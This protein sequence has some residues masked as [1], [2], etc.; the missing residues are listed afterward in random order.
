MAILINNKQTMFELSQ[1]SIRTKAKL[2]LDA[3]DCHD[4]ELS[5]LIVDDEQI[6][7]L[8]RNYLNRSGPTN[9]IAFP[10]C[11]GEFSHINPQLLG[12]VVISIATAQKEAET[13]G[14]SLE[15]RFDELLVHGILHLMGYDHEQTEEQAKQMW[16]KALVLDPSFSAAQK[17]MDALEEIRNE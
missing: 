13:A 12:D 11:E 7:E 3:L 9:V 8:N 10:M 6:E 15:N 1:E 4:A 5:I 17:N 16:E 2:I 14:S